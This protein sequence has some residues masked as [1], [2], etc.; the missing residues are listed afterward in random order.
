MSRR[1][2]LPSKDTR[3]PLGN[4]LQEA[5]K[6]VR[7]MATDFIKERGTAD[8]LSAAVTTWLWVNGMH[9]ESDAIEC[10]LLKKAMVRPDAG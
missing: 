3:R 1:T 8:A 10:A 5:A 9:E 4:E 7:D 6:Y 2:Y